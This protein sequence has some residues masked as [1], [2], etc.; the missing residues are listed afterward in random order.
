MAAFVP[1][2]LAAALVAVVASLSSAA[3]SS[4]PV[5]PSSLPAVLSVVFVAVAV[6]ASLSLAAPSSRSVLFSLYF[7]YLL[8]VVGVWLACSAMVCQQ[9][10][11]SARHWWVR[12]L[13]F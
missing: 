13:C 9:V 1:A 2:D 11:R 4:L 8:V 12:A 5:V 6:V 3:P 7:G 10:F